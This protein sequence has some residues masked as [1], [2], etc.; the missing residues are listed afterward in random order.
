M[1]Q[2]RYLLYLLKF[3]VP[4]SKTVDESGLLSKPI[5]KVLFARTQQVME[6]HRKRA[7]RC[8][9]GLLAVVAG[10][11]VALVDRGVGG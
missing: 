8:D 10:E 6:G 1:H 3:L 5:V 11:D 4:M 2:A 9:P 7:G